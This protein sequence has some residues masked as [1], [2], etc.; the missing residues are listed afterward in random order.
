MR[1]YRTI[2]VSI[3]KRPFVSLNHVR[4]TNSNAPSKGS[5]FFRRTDFY[6][7]QTKVKHIARLL[8]DPYLKRPKPEKS[9][10]QLIELLAQDEERSQVFNCEQC[11]Q[12]FSNKK[13]LQMHCNLLHSTHNEMVV[14]VNSRCR[15]RKRFDR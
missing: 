12:T 5:L 11:D 4:S 1:T 8:T 9:Q 2:H 14:A 15:Q 3:V 6:K 13:S 10:S 7:L